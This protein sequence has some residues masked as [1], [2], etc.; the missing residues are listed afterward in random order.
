M[1]WL[2]VLAAVWVPGCG[3]GSSP[4]QV[5][6]PDA[7]VGPPTV[8]SFEETP[9]F[10]HDSPRLVLAG[11]LDGDGKADLVVAGLGVSVLW[12]DG[13][14]TFGEPQSLTQQYAAD[15]ALVDLNGDGMTDIVVAARSSVIALL[16]GPP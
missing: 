3:G 15:V 2:R 6:L 4:G 10:A 11:D 13:N 16:N 1:K 5:A 14:G 8:P 12:N 9:G 7:S